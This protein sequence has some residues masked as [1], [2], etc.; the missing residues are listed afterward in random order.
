M[1]AFKCEACDM[2]GQIKGELQPGE[3]V[4]CPNCNSRYIAW[5]PGTGDGKTVQL[6]CVVK[7]VLADIF[8][9]EPDN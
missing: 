8:P 7:R 9:E 1:T 2:A 3:S 6:K 5:I 4:F